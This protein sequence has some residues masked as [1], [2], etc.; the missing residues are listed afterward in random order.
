[1]DTHG[2]A[3]P[4][5]DDPIR[6][7]PGRWALIGGGEG[8]VISPPNALVGLAALKREVEAHPDQFADHRPDLIAKSPALW[9]AL[10]RLGYWDHGYDADLADRPCDDAISPLTTEV[11]PFFPGIEPIDPAILFPILAPFVSPPT[12]GGTRTVVM[13]SPLGALSW[14]TF[15]GQRVSMTADTQASGPLGRR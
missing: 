6:N 5:T 10:G 7:P 11:N 13:R 12:P 15:D 3:G 2:R 1:M 8:T 9:W 14:W 4:N